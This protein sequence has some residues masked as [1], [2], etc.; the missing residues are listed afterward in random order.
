MNR[1]EIKGVR[2]TYSEILRVIGY[3]VD[4]ANLSEVRVLE[5]DDGL[6]LQGRLTK[7][8][9]VGE[10]ETYQLTVDDIEAL[11]LDAHAMRG[12]KVQ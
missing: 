10:R 3:D 7:G 11:L 2:K 12:K 9:K 5:T 4:K 6:I 1:I 8:D